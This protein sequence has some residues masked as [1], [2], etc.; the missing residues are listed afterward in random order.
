MSDA[1][2]ATVRHYAAMPTTLVAEVVV[3][4]STSSAL[5]QS[6]PPAPPLTRE[7]VLGRGAGGAFAVPVRAVACPGGR[8]PFCAVPDPA[9]HA[10]LLVE[11]DVALGTAALAAALA[12]WQ[13]WPGR[14]VGFPFGARGV[15]GPGRGGH[16]DRASADAGGAPVTEAPVWDAPL[17]AVVCGG[18]RSLV[19]PVGAVFHQ[20]YLA[21]AADPLGDAGAHA[22]APPSAPQAAALAA[23]RHALAGAGLAGVGAAGASH[24]AFAAGVVLAGGAPVV[25]GVPAPVLPAADV[26]LLLRHG[27]GLA[28]SPG[29]LRVLAAAV[30]G[31][32]A[33]A[34]LLAP[35]LGV[36][37]GG[38]DGGLQPLECPPV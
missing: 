20:A 7:D 19:L 6:E 16:R 17:A 1:L 27:H 35:A 12:A 21:P 22:G 4:W 26:A 18:R 31:A 33:L 2:Q 38:A 25:L 14:L 30:A 37:A 11:P 29:E 34:P 9:S 24:L 28:P 32:P 23:L 15:P 13:R 8:H 3:M 5:A 10:V 36:H